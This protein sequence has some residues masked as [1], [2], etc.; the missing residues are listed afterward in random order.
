MTFGLN[1]ASDFRCCDFNSD[2]HMFRRFLNTERIKKKYIEKTHADN[3]HAVKTHTERPH[4]DRHI[5]K[6]IL[7]SF[8]I[9]S[10]TNLTQIVNR[11]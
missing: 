10:W 4:A 8:L 2:S 9:R 11:S 3:T 1:I 5:L 7:N 6:Q